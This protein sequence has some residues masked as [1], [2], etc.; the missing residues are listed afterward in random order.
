MQ[1]SV[2]IRA[3][4]LGIR[5]ASS[6]MLSAFIASATSTVALQDLILTR[7]V[8]STGKHFNHYCS[9]WSPTFGQSPPP[10]SESSKQS[11]WDRPCIQADLNHL[12]ATPNALDKARLLAVSASH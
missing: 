8:G 6:L 7:T 3:G 11:V 12:L 1:T 2:P 4:R 9:A 10:E 5:R